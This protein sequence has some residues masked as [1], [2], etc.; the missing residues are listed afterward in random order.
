MHVSHFDYFCGNALIATNKLVEKMA[1]S[2]SLKSPIQGDSLSFGRQ[3]R[4]YNFGTGN[5]CLKRT[6]IRSDNKNNMQSNVYKSQNL[7]LK[8]VN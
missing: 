6:S 1:F 8:C 3:Y 2:S 7:A 4:R 5:V